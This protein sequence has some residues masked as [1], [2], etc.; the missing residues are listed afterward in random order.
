MGTKQGE[1][2]S[3]ATRQK[4]R[5]AWNRRSRVNPMKGKKYPPETAANMGSKKGCANP[6]KGVPRTEAER[7]SISAGTRAA[8]LRGPACPAW[9]GGVTEPTHPEL[10]FDVDN[11]ITLCVGCHKQEHAAKGGQV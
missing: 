4:M 9:K 6:R 1:T 7:A 3:E 2:H 5:D 10:R 11:G 8:A